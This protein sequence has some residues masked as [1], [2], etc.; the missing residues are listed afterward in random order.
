M[1][2][3]LQQ[4]AF[5]SK[6]AVV[7]DPTSFPHHSAASRAFEDARARLRR[8][9]LS[10]PGAQSLATA[11]FR[12]DADAFA[13]LHVEQTKHRKKYRLLEDRSFK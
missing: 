1:T 6:Q 9:E 3:R 4:T 10:M 11:R 7:Y 13:L 5:S 12:R 8:T 2:S